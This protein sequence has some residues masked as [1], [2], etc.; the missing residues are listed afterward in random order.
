MTV[1]PAVIHSITPTD[2]YV[3]RA[4]SVTSVSTASSSSSSVSSI[5]IKT[6]VDSSPKKQQS[7]KPLPIQKDRSESIST[8]EDHRP[9]QGKKY[10]VVYTNQN[11]NH[12]TRV[13]AEKQVYNQRRKVTTNVRFNERQT[14]YPPDVLARD[15]F[16]M[17]HLRA[18]V[19]NQHH[20]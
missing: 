16:M 15:R 6:P 10:Q 9:E 13:E 8:I 18:P 1:T 4:N 12:E 2:S 19:D 17:T 14:P 20:Q 5:S 7:R 11:N 3:S